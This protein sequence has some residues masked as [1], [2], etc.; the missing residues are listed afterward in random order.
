MKLKDIL[1]KIEDIQRRTKSSKV[2]ICGGVPRDKYI[3]KLNNISDLDLTTG[4]KTIDQISINLSNELNKKYNINR[5]VMDDG[6]SSIFLGNLKIDFSSN[7]INPNIE[8]ILFKIGVKDP[9]NIQKEMFS[10][11]FTCNSLLLSLDLKNILDPTS[12][13]LTDINNKIIKTCLSPE[14]TLTNNKNRVVRSIYLATKLDFNIDN[15]IVEYVKNNPKIIENSTPKTVSDK[16][17]FA[18]N[19]DPDKASFYLNK[20]NLW[21]YVPILE[22][23]T[24]YYLKYNKG[25]TNV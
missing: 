11:D 6:H 8:E 3:K 16:L 21:N 13:G 5:K 4:D 18:F 2:Y 23:M 7:F 17:N 25:K 14:I 1:N 9:S 12:K 10:R 24:P 15:S 22:S 20:M 19:K